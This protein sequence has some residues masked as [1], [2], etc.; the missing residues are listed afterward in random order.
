MKEKV[1]KKIEYEVLNVANEVVFSGN[2]PEALQWC[3]ENSNVANKVR[4]AGTDRILLVNIWIWLA[5]KVESAIKAREDKK[6][7]KEA[8]KEWRKKEKKQS[9]K[10][11]TL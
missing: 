8:K 5:E 9:K 1:Q 7:K 3:K 6:L 2:G 11:Q 10:Q 4:E